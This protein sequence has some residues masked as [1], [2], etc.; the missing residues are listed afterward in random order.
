MLLKDIKLNLL[1]Q[2][3][4]VIGLLYHRKLSRNVPQSDV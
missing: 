4:N 1:D 3:L 2:K